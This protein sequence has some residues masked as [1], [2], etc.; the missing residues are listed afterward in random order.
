MD[1]YA[2]L[3]DAMRPKAH[4]AQVETLSIG[5]GYT[6]ACTSDGGV[7]VA[8]T[9]EPDQPGCSM[10][11][12]DEEYEGCPASEA[13]A[14]LGSGRNL[15]RSI[16]LAVVN[17][18]NHAGAKAIPEDRDNT[19]LFDALGIGQGTRVA[20]VGC[21]TPIIGL[22]KER[23]AELEV[24][25]QGRGM[26]DEQAFKERLRSWAQAVIVTST[27][28]ING[29]FE[30]LLSCVADHARVALLGPSTPLVPEAFAGLPVHILAGTVPLD[31]AAVL[32]AVRNAKGTPVI[33]RFSR[34]S[35]LVL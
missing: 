16:G 20:M 3:Q 33:Q 13:L 31:A 19:I 24:V 15:H 2:R 22:I 6:C 4:G 5:L 28:I 30:E 35:L 27:S 21:F 25:D 12:P 1:F 7:G 23:G 34:K 9:P 18:L 8:Y 17:A 11:K 26:G 14:L 29:T 10:L 32:R